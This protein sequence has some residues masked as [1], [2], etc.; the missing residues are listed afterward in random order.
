VRSCMCNGLVRY[1]ELSF[2]SLFRYSERVNQGKPERLSSVDRAVSLLELVAD[3]DGM[4]LTQL[5]NRLGTGKTTVF[6][7]AASLL[8]RGWLV[9]DDE[10]RYRLGPGALALS[11]RTD[12]DS[13][14]K[15]VLGP[16]MGDLHQETQETIQLTR[17]E[18]R[19]VVYLEQFVSPRPVR[20][21]ATMG[22]RAPAHCVSSGL[23]QLA[24]LPASRLNWILRAP[25]TRYT[26]ASI[27]DPDELR[28]HL[29]LVRER[30]YGL[31]RGAY[32]EDVGGIGVAI[33]GAGG[34][35]I[36]GLS[37]CMPVY[38]MDEHDLEALG[39]MLI[40][41]A[42]D[43]SETIQAAHT[44]APASDGGTQPLYAAI[45]HIERL[46]PAAPVGQSLREA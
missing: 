25:L 44:R 38:R 14:L 6:R 1:A 10:L 30:G 12:P 24:A 46:S 22:T 42:R 17:L 27:T 23:A 7:L 33:C 8:D 31:N 4:S 20:S 15:A 28:R 45:P 32:R 19:Y 39:G 40:A 37:V 13:N 43:A 16:I 29:Q 18:G 36:A 5:A 26:D 21:L 9:K 3:S 34:E 35:P 11:A 41:A 2:I